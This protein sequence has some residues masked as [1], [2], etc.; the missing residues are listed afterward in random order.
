MLAIRNLLK[1]N[2]QILK[3]VAQQ[4]NMSVIA[5]PSRNKVSN[6]VSLSSILI[7]F[8]ILHKYFLVKLLIK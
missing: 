7:E 6:G 2:N 3:N 5:T 8:Y 4:R 1:V